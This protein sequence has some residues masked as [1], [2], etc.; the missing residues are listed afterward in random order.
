MAQKYR[1]HTWAEFNLASVYRILYIIFTPTPDNS[2]PLGCSAHALG[3]TLVNLATDS[4]KEFNNWPL[5]IGCDSSINLTE[6]FKNHLARFSRIS[7]VAC[8][9]NYKYKHELV[10][11][12]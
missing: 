4:S 3:I 6:I 12:W 9:L 10:L 2:F 8:F 5:D 11:T 1:H 7:S